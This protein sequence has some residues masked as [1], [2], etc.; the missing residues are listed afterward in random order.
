MHKIKH[1]VSWAKFSL[2]SLEL[3]SH[4]VPV[5]RVHDVIVVSVAYRVFQ[6]S[7]SYCPFSCY[8]LSL[9]FSFLVGIYLFI[10]HVQC[11]ACIYVCALH[12]CLMTRDDRKGC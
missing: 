6:V 11:F 1:L 9:S 8:G 12:A 5:I 3:Q 2:K 10:S 7:T 4:V